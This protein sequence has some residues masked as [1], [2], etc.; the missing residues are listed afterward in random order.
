MYNYYQLYKPY[1]MLSQFA[2]VKKKRTL[3]DLHYNFAEGTYALGRLDD[4]TEGLLLL[5]NNKKIS[6]ALMH[7]SNKHERKYWVQVHGTVN[8]TELNRLQQGVE[9]IL[10]GKIYTTLPCKA[11][12]VSP[13][14]NLPPRGHPVG[15]HFSTTWIELT[16]IEG[17]FH[18]IRKMTAAIGHQT[19]RLIRVSIENI[20]LNELIPGQII[21]LKEEEF[22]EKLKITLS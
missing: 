22:I 1:K 2:P 15:T 12:I 7:P 3:S 13:P 9:I 21:E 19:M 6:Q 4:N 17:K 18:Q 16:L 11:N 5:T 10:E 20:Y 8:E 14:Q